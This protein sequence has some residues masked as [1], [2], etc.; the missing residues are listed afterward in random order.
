M[1]RNKAKDKDPKLIKQ[2]KYSKEIYVES[3]TKG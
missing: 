2:L 1:L 3:N